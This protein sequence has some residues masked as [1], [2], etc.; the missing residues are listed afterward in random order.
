[1]HLADQ[2]DVVVVSVDYRLA[3]EHPFPLPAEDAIDAWKWVLE[4]VESLA[5]RPDRVLVGGDSAGGNLAA[6]VCQQ[7]LVRHYPSPH[8][9]ILIYPAT[10]L[11]RCHES[12]AEMGKGYVLTDDLVDWFVRSYLGDLGNAGL[13]LASPLL[14]TPE[15]LSCLPPA[16]VYTC[17]FDPLRDEGA[18]YARAMA[19]QKVPVEYHEF[20]H[21]LHGFVGMMGVSTQ[22]LAAGNEICA[23]I[24][25]LLARLGGIQTG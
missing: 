2:A 13:P 7:A 16:I 11:R 18:D 21:L 4:N 20:T 25:A 6:V 12:H 22:A 17:G 3:P 5:G 24:R 19:V 9:Q 10:D 14:A 8:A 1:M 15:L 23:Q